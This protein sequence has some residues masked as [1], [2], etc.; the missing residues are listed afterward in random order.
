MLSRK[1][2]TSL[3]FFF[4]LS[5]AMPPVAPLRRRSAHPVVNHAAPRAARRAL[6]VR[7]DP[8]AHPGPESAVP[9]DPDAA[10]ARAD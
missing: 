9:R 1:A 6:V 7:F 10:G 3:V 5:S 4:V 2:P 8:A